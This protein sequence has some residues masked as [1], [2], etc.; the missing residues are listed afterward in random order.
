MLALLVVGVSNAWANTEYY[1]VVYEGLTVSDISSAGYQLRRTDLTNGTLTNNNPNIGYIR[2][3][4]NR[5]TVTRLTTNNVST[6]IAPYTIAGYSAT[7]TVSGSSARDNNENID[8]FTITIHYSEMSDL[9][10]WND[11]TF[12]YSNYFTS[13]TGVTEKLPAGEVAIRL[14]LGDTETVTD[15]IGYNFN[16]GGG[17]H[18]DDDNDGVGTNATYTSIGTHAI[19]GANLYFYLRTHQIASS[20]KTS[21]IVPATVPGPDG[22][23]SYKVT[24]IQKWGFCY[25]QTHKMVISHCDD[26]DRWWAI[27]DHSNRHLTSVTFA[28]PSNVKK[29]G[30]YAFMSCTELQSVVLP[31]SLEYMG[32]GIFEQDYK[33]TDVRFQTRSDGT[34]ALETIKNFTFW[35]CTGMKSLELP[36]GIKEIEGS[37]SGAAMQYMLSLKN[38]RLPNTLETI[39][40][41]FLCCASSLES[42]TIPASVKTIDGACF[43]GCMRLRNV[44][45]LGPVSA[46]QREYTEGGQ[47]STTFSANSTFCKDQ[48]QDC[49]FWVNE[50]AYDDY[51]AHPVW[52]LINETTF[53]EDFT[54][55]ISQ[56]G[57]R[58]AL[59]KIINEKRV[60]PAKW[61][62]AIFP[63][64]VENYVT[65]FGTGTRVAVMDPAARHTVTYEY[66]ASVGKSVAVYNI[67]FKLIEGTAIPAKTPVMICA[68]QQTEYVMYTSQQASTEEFKQESSQPHPTDVTA[69]DGSKISMRGQYVPYTTHPWDF[70]FMYKDKTQNADGTWTYPSDPA[71]FYRVPDA[72]NAATVG[73]CR[74][75]WR[76]E[77]NNTKTDGSM[78]PAKSSKFFDFDETT[79]INNIENRIRIEGI[80][81]MQGRKLD[82]KQSELPQ[83]LYIVNGK[84]V[85]KQ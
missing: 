29:I 3:Y 1:H 61:V 71:K 42:L 15:T 85:V 25:K 58:N 49:T 80:Y 72:D 45:L 81:D 68:G 66:D 34:V 13:S 70:Y 7:M 31:N 11:G 52:N 47:T 74:C 41:H 27:D 78:A 51:V 63:Y 20:K 24:A 14:Y 84:K 22:T 26:A 50:E 46:L 54:E 48:V 76:L 4:R 69:V 12:E 5:G 19:S 28:N 6:Y 17:T 37:Q 83:G 60:F 23:G 21:V 16:H 64:G 62:T 9:I 38:V 82:I 18:A 57:D 40:A 33:L 35:L 53:N 10:T 77:V 36:D 43:H 8:V 59:R 39:G 56:T 75:W 32:D 44:Y 55:V 73:I 65:S 30:D 67:V 79:G 2:A